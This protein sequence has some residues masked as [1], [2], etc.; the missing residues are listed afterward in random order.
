MQAWTSL[1][2][3]RGPVVVGVDG[4][5]SALN[6]VT[7]AVAE[8]VDRDVPLRIVHALGAE[9]EPR[10]GENDAVSHVLARAEDA[11]HQ[12]DDSVS[13]EVV[14]SLGRPGDVLVCESRRASLICVGSHPRPCDESALFSPTVARLAQRAACPVAIIRSRRDGTPQTDG[15]ITVV[16]SDEPA[17]DDLVRVAMHE[18]RLRGATVRQIDQRTDSWVRRYPDVHVEIVTDTAGLRS[19]PDT[20]E[21][22]PRIGLAVV[23]PADTEALGSLTIPNSHPIHGFPDCSVLVVRG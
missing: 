5:R 3:P 18:G 20:T 2:P 21:S 15:V 12:A 13:T 17:N 16:L 1:S 8:A 7:W 23:G 9:P 14:T 11:A 19:H 22:D 6:A 10:P 4:S